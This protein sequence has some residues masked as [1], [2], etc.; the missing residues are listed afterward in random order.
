M[1]GSRLAFVLLL[2]AV[3]TPVVA[4]VGHPPH[5]SPYRDIVAGMSLVPQVGFFRGN[6]GQLGIAPHAGMLSGAR[7]DLISSRTIT[8]GFEVASGTLERLIVDADDPVTERVTG[9]VDQRLSMIGMNLLL[10]LTGSKSWR[11]IAPY[12]GA[13][14]GFA[15]APKVAADT[16]GFNY[17][18]KFYFAPTVGVRLFLGPRVFL[19]AEAR[20]FFAQVKYPTSYFDE[21]AQDPGT[22]GNSNAVLAGGRLKEWTTS[23]LYT[24]GIGIPFPW[25]F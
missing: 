24:F 18:T 10:N 3:A 15:F 22:G 5:R 6:G 25:P 4:Q 8:L 9:P 21:P 20:S 7:A 14:A 2:T 13:G 1:P 19:R 12:L 16:S 11:G 17:G 23:G